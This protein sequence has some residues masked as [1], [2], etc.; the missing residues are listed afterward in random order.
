MS[1][2]TPKFATGGKHACA[3]CGKGWDADALEDIPDLEQRVEPG[4]EVPSG[5]CPDPDCGALCY[6]VPKNEP[7]RHRLFK[8]YAGAAQPENPAF[9]LCLATTPREAAK[10]A[11]EAFAEGGKRFKRFQAVELCLPEGGKG[12]VY[13]PNSDGERIFIP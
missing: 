10:I 12:L 3:N 9:Q 8:V 1:R 4:G 7:R 11:R 5:A 6:P 2:K 13:E